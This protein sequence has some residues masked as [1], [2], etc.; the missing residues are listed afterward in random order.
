MLYLNMCT[1]SGGKPCKAKSASM[2]NGIQE[3]I[4][5]MDLSREI[6]I[7]IWDHPKMT[8]MH[9]VVFINY[10]SEV[11]SETTNKSV[12]APRTFSIE[13]L[14]EQNERRHRVGIRGPI[15]EL[16][17]YSCKDFYVI[18]ATMNQL[19]DI[20][21]KTIN[22][23]GEYETYTNNGRCFAMNLLKNVRKEIQPAPMS[24]SSK[25]LTEWLHE[26]SAPSKSY[27]AA[28]AN[29]QLREKSNEVLPCST[30]QSKS[31]YAARTRCSIEM[32]K[33]K[34]KK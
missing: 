8:K 33:E 17:G 31:Y 16:R 18:N 24:V 22:A 15:S 4:T 28:L 10:I 5:R 12:I 3:G 32:K 21:K 26:H 9:Q 30:G 7:G 23:H 1:L 20:G 13:L 11:T 6:L 29:Q 2:K 34:S 19:I 14:M 25:R 27:Y